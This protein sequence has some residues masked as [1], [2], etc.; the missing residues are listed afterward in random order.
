VATPAA[1]A[2]FR[3]VT[4]D[5]E[6]GAPASGFVPAEGGLVAGSVGPV[7]VP[8][9]PGRYL[10]VTPP[11]PVESRG[12]PLLDEQGRVLGILLGGAEAGRLA[13]ASDTI[14][15]SASFAVRASTAWSF[16]EAQGVRAEAPAPDAAAGA[17]LEEQARGFT[18]VLEC[19][20]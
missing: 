12:A 14:P 7:A 2:P 19:R 5:A 6:P 16:L 13:R 9:E 10:R 8:G 20:R 4:G 17:A 1:P 3:G 18:V 15:G 11:V